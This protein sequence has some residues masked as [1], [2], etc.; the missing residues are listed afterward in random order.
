MEKKRLL[1]THN[2]VLFALFIALTVVMTILI[3]IPIPLSQ[4]YF[5]IGDS[6]LLLAS[7]LL[8]PGAGFFI[9]GIGS[10]LADL[11]TGYTFYAPIT[12]V[13]KGLEGF[14]CGWLFLKMN[15]TKPLVPA[16]LAGIWMA[17]GYFFGDW[18]LFGIAAGIAAFPINLL[19][20]LI[21]G[22]LATLF[23]TFVKPVFDK[24]MH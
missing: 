9:G 16:L 20:G 1:S 8:G 22:G 15:R 21:G 23:Y 2:I 24:R 12:F 11:F 18:L 10:A 7:M 13:V 19:Q 14:L 3:R 5:N 4:G 17:I 6:I